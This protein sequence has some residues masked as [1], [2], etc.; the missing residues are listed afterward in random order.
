M[1]ILLLLTLSISA[2]AAQVKLTIA[3]PDGRTSFYL[4]ET[5]PVV[6]TFEGLIEKTHFVRMSAVNRPDQWPGLDE[7]TLDPAEGVEDPFAH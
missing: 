3:V 5:I 6:L 7:F 2:C 1:R 4:D